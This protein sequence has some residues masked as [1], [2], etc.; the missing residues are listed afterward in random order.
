MLLLG[1]LPWSSIITYRAVRFRPATSLDRSLEHRLLSRAAG[2]VTVSDELAGILRGKYSAP[3][4]TI[5]HS[6]ERREHS[7]STRAAGDPELR[8]IYTG[9][10]HDGRRDPLPLF[11]SLVRLQSEGVSVGFD[12]YGP[13]SEI[14][15]RKAAEAGSPSYVRALGMVP[16][17]QALQAQADADALVLLMWNHPNET[18]SVTGKLFEYIGAAKP[19]LVIGAPHSAAGILVTREHLGF[20][21]STDDET[22]DWLCAVAAAKREGRLAPLDI[23]STRGFSRQEQI[24]RLSEFLETCVQNTTA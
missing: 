15:L 11:R 18:G 3:V 1:V 10:L 7:V 9:C 12:Y 6:F 17:A 14:V 4:I 23:G 5:Y 21:P 20:A 22:F 24:G 2:L 8:L 13:D 16:N 19:I